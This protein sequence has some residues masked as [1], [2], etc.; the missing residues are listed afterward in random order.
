[1][2]RSDRCG[3]S[4]PREPCS[5]RLANALDPCLGGS[6][7]RRPTP[8]KQCE[9][10]RGFTLIELLVVIAVIAILA[11]VLM[12]VFAQARK[13]AHRASCGS[14]CR[15]V[16][17]AIM[18]YAADRDSRLPPALTNILTP[19]REAYAGY[20][21]VVTWP[22][23]CRNYF[24]ANEYS[25][26]TWRITRCPAMLGDPW[27]DTRTGDPQPIY[28]DNNGW[29][30]WSNWGLLSSPGYNYLAFSPFDKPGWPHPMSTSTPARPGKTLLLVETKYIDAKD[31]RLGWSY[32]YF[33]V[34]P[35]LGTGTYSEFAHWWYGGWAKYE[36]PAA[37][38][39]ETANVVW[40]DGHSSSLT[41]QQLED[42]SIW[43]LG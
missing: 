26:K 32:G 9:P 27:K 41:M 35:K 38:H 16:Y 1:M 29:S 20:A 12:P 17:D 23:W 4:R 22:V 24:K 28:G 7:L 31:P 18:M 40:A 19:G 14:Q 36:W 15:Q 25:G 34:E 37:R 11:A 30:W 33:V 3:G 13:S 42:E 43:D 21:G 10:G 6:E 8:R 39:Q 5:G 2:H